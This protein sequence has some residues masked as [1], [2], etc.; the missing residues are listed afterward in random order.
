MSRSLIARAAGLLT[1]GLVVAG[2]AGCVTAPPTPAAAPSSAAASPAA[3]AAPVVCNNA[4]QSYAKVT[5]S[6]YAD[7]IAKRG[8]LLVGVSADTRQLGAVDPSNPDVFAGFDIEIARLV[9]NK[10]GVNLRFKVI[11]TADRIAQL[12]KEVS[13]GGVDLVARAFTM[14]CA[15]WKDISFSQVYFLAHQGLMV[16]ASS[17][18]AKLAGQPDKVKQALSGETV[19]A[20]KGSTSLDNITTWAPGVKTRAVANHTDCLVLLQQ[21]QVDAI[22]G[23]DAILAGFKAQDPTTLVLPGI[24]LS[25]EP[26]G[27]GVNATHKDFAAYVNG[28]LEEARTSGAWQKAYDTYLKGPLGKPGVQP[29]P[30]YGRA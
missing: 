9:A 21:G 18:L 16:P 27:L 10:L 25:D 19:C 11:T 15:R 1:A 30:S 17:T 28:V 13:A 5:S 3:P 2:L 8:Y 22:T 12:K 6:P 14:N 26:Y 7:V 24:E 23:D 20:P 29:A 4:T